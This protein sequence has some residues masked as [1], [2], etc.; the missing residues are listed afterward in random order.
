MNSKNNFSGRNLAKKVGG[1]GLIAVMAV[2]LFVYREELLKL[3]LQFSSLVTDREH[4]S[5]LINSYGGAAP[6]VFIGLQILQVIFAPVP[7]EATGFI[8]GYVFG[9]LPGFVYSSIGLT[10]G[11][12]INLL[13]GRY[14]GKRVV[15]RIISAERM[16]KFDAILK[17]QG[18]I[19]FFILFVI[20]GFPKDYLCLF[21]GLSRVSMKVLVLIAAVGRIPGTLLLSIQGAYLFEKNYLLL[22]VV[23]AV[24]AGIAFLSFKYKEKIYQWVASF[25][26]R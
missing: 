17:R 1:G 16:E 22:G 23:L 12:L 14:L 3:L 4:V 18:I 9:M 25:N 5:A 20:P 10:I 15:R 8:G 6:L 2:L 13:I 19:V 11:S 21:L 24:C 26:G 7:G